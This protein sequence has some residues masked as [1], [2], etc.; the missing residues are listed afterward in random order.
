ML[1]LFIEGFIFAIGLHSIFGV[2]YF[3]FKKIGE[4]IE[5]SKVQL[6]SDDEWHVSAPM[7]WHPRYNYFA[8]FMATFSGSI[9]LYMLGKWIINKF[10]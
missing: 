1:K 3:I 2:G 7:V 8:I 6:G 10:L 5:R 9:V 4:I